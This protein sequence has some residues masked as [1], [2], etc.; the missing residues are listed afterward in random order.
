MGGSAGE[1]Y[2]ENDGCEP[3]LPH[4]GGLPD[5][6]TYLNSIR[7]KYPNKV[8]ANTEQPENSSGSL[9]RDILARQRPETN[10]NR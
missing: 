2:S 6:S 4:L 3:G 10:I 1:I 5:A 7:Q 8:Y 9:K